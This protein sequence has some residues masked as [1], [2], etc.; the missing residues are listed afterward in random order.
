MTVTLRPAR[1]TDAGQIG[2][3]LHGFETSTPWMSKQHS[4]A[5]AIAFCGAMIDRGWVTV[6]V[7]ERRTL[8][9]L[10]QDQEEICSLYVAQ[11]ARGQGIGQMLL[12]HAKSC[13]NRLNLWTF[14]AN[15]GAQRFYERAGFVEARRTDGQG[16]DERLPDIAYVWPDP[17]TA[18]KAAQTNKTSEG[19]A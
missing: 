15:T 16:N 3:I 19:R 7:E 10:A 18:A 5:E 1:S 13:S 2:E 9:F 17:A 8:G 14:Q 11:D 12:A 6:A 4:G